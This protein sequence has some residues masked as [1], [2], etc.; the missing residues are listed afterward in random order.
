MSEK[1][2]AD[3]ADLTQEYVYIQAYGTGVIC[4]EKL[5]MATFS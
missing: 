5:G 3:N 4:G 2:A 1:P